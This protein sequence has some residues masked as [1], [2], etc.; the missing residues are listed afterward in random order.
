MISNLSKFIS[1]GPETCSAC[2]KP[3]PAEAD[4]LD[5]GTYN[6]CKRCVGWAYYVLKLKPEWEAEKGGNVESYKEG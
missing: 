6:F 4:F 2:G 5:G 1:P 3:I